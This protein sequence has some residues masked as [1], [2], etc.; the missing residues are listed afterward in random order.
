MRLHMRKRVLALGLDPVFTDFAE[1]PELTPDLIRA[2]I[3]S[4]LERLRDLEFEV[5]S[6]LV[7]LGNT[8]EAVLGEHLRSRSFDC[9]VIGAGLRTP[10]Q[11]LLFEKVL[12]L[13]HAQAPHTK[14]CSIPH[15]PTLQKQ[16][17]AG[18]DL[19]LLCS[20]SYERVTTP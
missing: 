5:D 4:Q 11:L 3:Y 17:S 8:A 2:F 9:V 13:V 7:D 14:I 15:L 19:S 20:V 18:S 6:C 16:C 1:F 12:N 10:K